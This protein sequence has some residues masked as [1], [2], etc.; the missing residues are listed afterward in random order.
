VN[1]RVSIIILNW[2]GLEDTAACLQSLKEITYPNYDVILVDNGSKGN[3]AKVLRETFGDHIYIIENDKNYGFAE[4]CNIGMRYALK[5]SAPDYILLLNNDTTVAPDFLAEMVKIAESDPLI[6]IAGPKIYFYNESNKIQSAGGRIDW[7]RG[8]AILMGLFEIDRGQF[9]EVKE[10]DWVSG[11]A[12]LI[13]LDTIKRIGLLEPAYF[14]YLEETDW[15]ARCKKAG[16]KVVYAPKAKVW[17]KGRMALDELYVLPLY[18]T[19]RNRF[20]FM[21]KHATTP[22]FVSFFTQLVLRE[23]L[24]VTLVSLLVRQRN[25]KL[26]PSYYRGTCDGIR[27]ILSS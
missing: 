19:T 8:K 22:Q 23:L 15:C 21:K 14:T 27:L 20:L 17:H 5:N 4:G 3:D 16:Y 6:G 13:K 2:N 18:Y 24:P 26:L 25:V 9:E 7:W 11:C 12:L 10:V 1:P